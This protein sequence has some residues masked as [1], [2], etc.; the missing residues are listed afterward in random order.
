MLS[1]DVTGTLAPAIS[2]SY[3]ITEQDLVSIAAS[4]KTHILH[5][6]EEQKNGLHSWTEDPYDDAVVK[7]VIDLVRQKKTERIETVVWIGIG[8]SALGPKVLQEA[9][10]SPNTIEFIVLD[11]LDPTTLQTTLNILDWK[12][13]LVV[14]ASKSGTTLESMSVFFLLWQKL[15]SVHKEHAAQFVIAITDPDEG[16]LQQFT[17]EHSIDLLP[18][19]RETGGRFSIFTSIGL[20]PLALL[21]RDVHSFVEGARAMNEQCQKTTMEEN[22]AL[23][24]AGVQ[25]LLDTKKNYPLRVI[26]PYAHRI[27]SIAS[28]DQQLIAESLGKTETHNPIPIAA[29]GTADQHSLLQ[30]WMAGPRKYWHLFIRENTHE[31]LALPDDTPEGFEYLRGKSFGPLLDA[32]ADGTREALTKAKRPHA[33]M[34]LTTIDEYHLGQLFTCLMTEVLLLGKLYRIDPYGQPAVEIGK[35]ITKKILSEK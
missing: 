32:C 1:L 11:T 17:R 30:Q 31:D 35:K 29:I 12:R 18:I 28:W 5:F 15:R 23:L 10:E 13:T 9:F 33:T 25:F 34:S 2:P 21:D 6:N 22:P 14:I 19:P 27:R 24:L 20:L 3:G 16:P 26:M 4:L 7:R 8:G